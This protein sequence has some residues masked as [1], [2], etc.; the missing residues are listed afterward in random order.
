[1]DYFIDWV[2]YQYDMEYL[3]YCC[4]YLQVN[5]LVDLISGNLKL[6]NGIDWYLQIDSTLISPLKWNHKGHP[7][8]NAF[9]NLLSKP[10][11]IIC[12]IR[13]LTHPLGTEISS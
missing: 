2:C 3:N 5:T 6:L 1:M 10:G 12:G 8:S 11:S 4:V 9:T 7:S 13:Y